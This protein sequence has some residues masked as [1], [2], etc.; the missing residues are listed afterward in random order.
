MVAEKI[1]EPASGR[2]VK[3]KALVVIMKCGQKRVAGV[4]LYVR[5]QHVK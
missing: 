1:E 3:K 5:P 4:A 2:G